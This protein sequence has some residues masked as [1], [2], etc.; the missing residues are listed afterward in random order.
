MVRW[1]AGCI[2]TI[3]MAAGTAM[4]DPAGVAKSHS[5]AFA[6]AFNACDVPAMLALYEDNAIV[7]WPG[8][9]E[10][11]SGKTEIERMM[12]QQCAGGPKPAL[13]LVS[14]DARAIGK[15]YIVNVGMWDDTIPGPGGKPMTA[16]VRTTEVLHRSDGKWRYVVDHAS[17]GLPPPPPPKP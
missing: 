6:A 1:M 13:K 4:A 9:G 7:I 5:D 8:Q 15:D 11:A 10:V 12:K 2:V 16:R 17:I 14:S 3:L